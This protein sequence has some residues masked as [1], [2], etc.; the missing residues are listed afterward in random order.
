MNRASI[1]GATPAA[2]TGAGV[3]SCPVGAGRRARPAL[4]RWVRSSR[5]TARRPGA[6]RGGALAPRRLHRRLEAPVDGTDRGQL[7]EVS[8]EADG[9]PGQHRGPDR[10][11]LG[12]DRALDRHI[13]QVRL[14]LAQP[15]VRGGAAID[16]EHLEGDPGVG[17]HRPDHVGHLVGHRVDRGPGDLGQAGPPGDPDEGPPGVGIPVRRAEPDERRHEVDPAGVGHGLRQPGD[18]GGVA[19]GLQAVAQPLDRGAGHEGRALE[20][21]D[22]PALPQPPADRRQEPVRRGHRPLAGVHQEEGTGPVGRLG[23]SRLEAGLAE[24]R[25]LLVAGAARDRDRSTEQVGVRLARGPRTTNGPRAASPA[26][27]R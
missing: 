13:Q 8:P 11:G 22:G 19:A 12:V 5:A 1:V 25:R 9:K 24:G 18:L 4:S 16:P 15:V 14:E 20:G 17:D 26:G 10:R 2:T 3:V 21:I 7:G 23:R 27:P 6:S